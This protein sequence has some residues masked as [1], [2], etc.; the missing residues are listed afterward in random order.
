M[1]LCD[2]VVA[3]EVARFSG[4]ESPTSLEL[5]SLRTPVPVTL[6]HGVHTPPSP[7]LTY[8]RSWTSLWVSIPYRLESRPTICLSADGM[9]VCEN[10]NSFWSS[11]WLSAVSFGMAWRGFDRNIAFL[12]RFRRTLVCPSEWSRWRRPPH[13]APALYCHELIGWLSCLTTSPS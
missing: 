12:W 2:I 6:G 5:L 8:S 11:R 9:C 7:V 4:L 10:S 1:N 3:D 13:G